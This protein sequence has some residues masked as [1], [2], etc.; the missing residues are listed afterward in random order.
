MSLTLTARQYEIIKFIHRYRRRHSLAPTLAEIAD[1][2]GISKVTVHEH[3]AQLEQK[4]ALEKVPFISRSTRLTRRMLR[5][6]EKNTEEQSRF[7]GLEG[8]DLPEEEEH[9]RKNGK[10]GVSGARRRAMSLPLLGEIAAGRPL[11]AIETRESVDLAELCKFERAHYVLRVRG[12]SMI[13]DGIHDGDYVLVER[14]ND[15]RDGETVVA[16]L[17]NDEATLKRF[18][19]QKNRFKL[20]PANAALKPIYVDKVEVR[21]VVVGVVRSC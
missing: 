6:L 21:G 20:E 13:E 15:A 16:I 17:E 1:E 11:E 10:N 3:I 18:Y 2:L 9:G 4:G 5:E 7:V 12:D 8:P 14:R 19:R